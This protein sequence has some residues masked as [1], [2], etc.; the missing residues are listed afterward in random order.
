M[1]TKEEIN[2]KIGELTHTETSK[3][4]FIVKYCES[5]RNKHIIDED[6]IKDLSN[7]YAEIYILKENLTRRLIKLLKQDHMID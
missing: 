5:I 1:K 7:M 4:D 3:L 6:T 2:K